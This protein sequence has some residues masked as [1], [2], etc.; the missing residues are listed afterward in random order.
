MRKSTVAIIALSLALVGSKETLIY[1]SC[2]IMRSR[3][4]RNGDE[5]DDADGV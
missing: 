4:R 3:S 2:L 5:A 1:P